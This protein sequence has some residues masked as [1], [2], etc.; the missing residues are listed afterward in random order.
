MTRCP[1]KS[2]L[3]QCT[4]NLEVELRVSEKP[5]DIFEQTPETDD[6]LKNLGNFPIHIR[7]AQ[8]WTTPKHDCLEDV[9]QLSEVPS[10]NADNT[11][12]GDVDFPVINKEDLKIKIKPETAKAKV[13]SVKT[14]ADMFDFRLGDNIKHIKEDKIINKITKNKSSCTEC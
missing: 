14:L 1:A 2:H 10:K 12:I 7:Q 3:N 6:L 13:L 4:C 11:K 8:K 9:T 5:V